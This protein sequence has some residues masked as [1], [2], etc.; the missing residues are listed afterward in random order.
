MKRILST[1]LIF[2]LLISQFSFFVP[3]VY[4][5]SSP[6]TQTDW[7]G[8]NGTSTTNQF[9][10]SSSVTTS[11]AG[12]ATLTA[13][14]NWYNSSWKYRK[15]ITLANT[16]AN[17]GVTAT[18]LTNFP[19]LVKLDSTRI[20]YANTQGNGED[21][22]FTDSDG[23]T[24]LSYEIE[25][26]DE[27][28]SSFVW[29]KV[30]S[31]DTTGT[32]YIYVYYGNS[33]VA[34]GQAATSVWDSNYKGVWHLSENPAGSAPQIKDSTTNANN[35]TSNGSMTSSQQVS[36]QIDGSVSFDGTNDYLN[37]G[38]SN[39][40]T[41]SDNFTISAWVFPTAYH[42]TGFFGL[43]NQFIARG[44]A[45]TY[46][47]SLATKNATT[48]TFTKRTSPESLEN[49]DFT[50]VPSMKNKWTYVA[51]KVSGNTVTLYINGS[52]FGSINIA[53]L[54]IAGVA[55]DSLYIGQGVPGQSETAFTGKLDDIHISNAVRSAVWIAAEYKNGTDAFNS[56]ASEEPQIATSGTLTSA[57]FD[58]GASY[59]WTT[60]SYSVTTPSNTSAS[61]KVRSGNQSDLS[62][63]TAFSSCTTITSGQSL[64]TG[65]CVTNGHR[66][67]QYQVSLSNTD[68]V[69]TP[70]LT[71]VSVNYQ[72]T[73]P[74]SLS[75][76]PAGSNS[77][78]WSWTDNSSVESGF[79]V[80]DTDGNTKCTVSSA[81]TTT[82]TESSLSPNTSYTRRVVAYNA[83]GNSSA[84]SNASA[85]TLSTAPTTSN[86]TSSPS[87]SAWTNN[88]TFTFTNGI[89]FSAGGAEYL[90]YAWDTSS[91][92]TWSGSETQW[93]SGTL[94]QTATSDSNSW[95]LHLKGYNSNNTENGTLDFGPFYYD[96]TAPAS[97]DLDSP[98]ADSYITTERPTYKWKTTTDATAV[99]F[100]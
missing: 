15:K 94:T 42:T 36:G 27:T 81:S 13:T 74:S 56:F 5:A 96:G 82:C 10:S 58:A 32:D 34:D 6:W 93:T 90:R 43:F 86:I 73:A 83:S 55:G 78:T 14:S 99:V 66:Y 39:S 57:I 4:A 9:S 97:F 61:V 87:T 71:S 52:L 91:T 85:V 70:T 46:N 44:P 21:I 1:L 89:G 79:Y 19:V 17:L 64:S 98:G 62:D 11:T 53:G 68:A 18:T 69:S 67:V 28:S 63:A 100:I 3:F 8:G 33:S 54:P 95:Y 84:S 75:G 47:Y 50:G 38:T 25:K 65:G 22:R 40:L 7:S 48:I 88:S 59:D 49:L 30:P 51:T 37:G 26:W 12:Q 77:I 20:D 45:S 29:V 24:A 72:L 92:H 35:A 80:Q 23:T 76:A 16:T 60:L 2:S 41:F 31:I